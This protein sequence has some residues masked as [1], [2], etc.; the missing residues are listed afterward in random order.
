MST[1]T[2]VTWWQTGSGL[3]IGKTFRLLTKQSPLLR[4]KENSIT[5]RYHRL[6]INDRTATE[7]RTIKNIIEQEENNIRSNNISETSELT[8]EHFTLQ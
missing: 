4:R 6:F 5:A 2:L 7:K 3:N 1:V 8:A